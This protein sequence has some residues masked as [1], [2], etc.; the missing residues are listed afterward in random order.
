MRRFNTI[1][2]SANPPGIN[3]LWIDK[4]KLRY[5]TEGKWH[6]LGDGGSNPPEIS[7][8]DTWIIDGEDTGKPTRGEEGS[9]G[10]NGLTPFIG[11]NKHWW[12]G[13]TDTGVVAEG[14][15]GIDG[16]NGLTPQLRV[17]D[18][19]VE[20]SYDGITWTE[21]IPKS[22]FVINYNSEIYNNPD[23]EDITVVDEKLKFKDKPHS[24]A[25]F[26]GLGRVYLRKNVVGD[27]NVLT[28]DMINQPST[29][30]HI[31][32]DYDLDGRTVVVPNN[33][34]LLFEGGSLSNGTIVGNDTI[35]SAQLI[36]IFNEDISLD[37]TWKINGIYPEWYGATSYKKDIINNSTGA[38]TLKES[39]IDSNDAFDKVKEVLINTNVHTII[40]SALYYVTK[41]IDINVVAY[42]T[43]GT[44]IIGN[45]TDTGLIASINNTTASVLS[46]NKNNNTISQYDYLSNFAIYI[47]K[48]S[49]L[50]SAILLY[51]IIR[52]TCVDV[53]VYGGF[54]KFEKGIYH[55]HSVVNNNIF[56]NVFER[57]VGVNSIKGGGIHYSHETYQPTLQSIQNCIFQQLAGAAI[58]AEPTPITGGGF[59]GIIQGNELEGNIK[60]AIA[61]SGIHNL[62]VRNNYF[63]CADYNQLINYFDNV[64]PAVFT[65]GIIQ[66]ATGANYVTNVSNLE[67][68]N[69]QIGAPAGSIDYAIIICSTQ[70]GGRTRNVNISNNII[71]TSTTKNIGPKYITKVQHCSGININDNLFSIN[72]DDVNANFP[73]DLNDTSSNGINYSYQSIKTSFSSA[74][75][76][77]YQTNI[78]ILRTNG[79]NTETNYPYLTPNKSG[80]TVTLST[81]DFILLESNN[82]IYKVLKG[83]RLH[84]HT[85]AKF[86]QGSNVVVCS[87]SIWDWKVGDVVNSDYI[88]NGTATITAI[89]GNNFTLSENAIA[90]IND[91][92]TDA[93]VLPYE[94]S[95][96]IRTSGTTSQRPNYRYTKIPNGF[97]YFDTSLGKPTWWNGTA[98]ITYPD[99]S[100]STM[101]TLTF[102]GAVEA[103]YNGSTPVTVNIPTGGG[104]TTNYEDLSNK[105]KIGDVE[106]V[107]T[108][109]LVQLGI[110][111]AGDYATETYVTEQIA[112]AVG[113]INSVLDTI[114]GEVI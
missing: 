95:S 41:E 39:L 105:P 78:G 16:D 111:P 73:I 101:A 114:N 57:C 25:T 31:Q 3:Q 93:I 97:K 59:G 89:D 40:L 2:E 19:A 86:T 27:K 99:S 63:E 79:F 26:S 66:G 90:T 50:D 100:G 24:A 34:I 80:I 112:A 87:I 104:G 49:Q 44:N 98:W 83:G 110:Q 94:L 103:T 82:T 70:S 43:N 69:N 76:Y 107:G 60:G 35:I 77:G 109:T 6:L 74:Y 8:H 54:A 85:S 7:D 29:I 36:K 102:T 67:I 106:L 113:N 4:K 42:Y 61:L 22:D 38:I 15:D 21:L 28:Q 92:L 91:W 51:E 17:T 84:Y 64:P 5:F 58:E 13:T 12:I 62:S 48:D 55:L 65:F 47:T 68:S 11:T 9:K 23:E 46:I 71:N 96:A 53:K 56:L 81:G 72:Y 20:Y 30:Y 45:G 10:D 88:N 52:S 33:C 75:K 18:T 14:T 37:G 108:K 1:I 32:Y